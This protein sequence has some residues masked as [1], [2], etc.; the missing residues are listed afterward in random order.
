MKYYR[1]LTL[2]CTVLVGAALVGG[3]DP[4]DTTFA[5][6]E[7]AMTYK[8]KK[9]TDVPDTPSDVTVMDW[10]VKFGGGRID[11][12]FDCYGK[13]VLMTH[14]EVI[15]NLKGLA[16]KIRQVDPDVLTLEEVDV[17][18]KRAAYVDE[19]QWLLDHTD[20]NY[21]VYA[22]QWS[23]D[24]VPSDGLGRVNSGNA[25]LSK[26]PLT[27]GTRRALPLIS[28]QDALTRYFYL[29]R[30][31]LEAQVQ[32][33]DKP[34]WVLVTHTSAYSKDGTKKK[35]LDLFHKRLQELD[36]A[37]E[38]FVGGGDFNT[39]P[40][41]TQK[42]HDFD[43]SVCKDADF[44]ADDYRPEKGWL[45]PMYQDFQPAISLDDYRQ[46]NAEYFSHTVNKDGF[47]NRKLDYLFTNASFVAGSGLVHQDVDHGGMETMPLS[48]HAPLS[49]TL[50]LP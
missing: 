10:N 33:G 37:G 46:N 4:F 49:V 27:D 8:A 36:D 44:T 1:P 22:S 47:W 32:A 45:D 29:R 23:A 14:D 5:D 38:V 48:D 2:I 15:H 9:L 7:P 50:E 6:I 18:S 28:E 26:W 12:F 16:K 13:R 43:D 11:F 17:D 42:W 39:L 19:L 35:Q 25:I 21:A 3:C 24:Y 40:P 20:L 34:F 31:I 41:G 30:N